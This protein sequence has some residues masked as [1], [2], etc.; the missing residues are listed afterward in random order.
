MVYQPIPF[1]SEINYRESKASTGLADKITFV[2]YN[3]DNKE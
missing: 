1:N 2:F 3:P